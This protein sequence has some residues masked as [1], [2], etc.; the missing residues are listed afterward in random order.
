MCD[1]G[2]ACL[3][4][5]AV[6]RHSVDS[7]NPVADF[8]CALRA[9]AAWS[10]LERCSTAGMQTQGPIHDLCTLLY[11]FA[12]KLAGVF[13]LSVVMMF[14]AESPRPTPAVHPSRVTSTTSGLA[15]LGDWFTV[16]GIRRKVGQLCSAPRADSAV[17]AAEGYMG[18]VGAA[19]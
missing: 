12:G 16:E 17:L 10:E 14:S 7:Q 1:P 4:G 2:P 18:T 19:A 9:K 3:E 8:E 13:G 11:A 15:I 6:E 5:F